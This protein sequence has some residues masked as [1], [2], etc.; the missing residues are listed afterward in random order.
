MRPY[1]RPRRAAAIRRE[2]GRDFLQIRALYEEA[3]PRALL[4]ADRALDCMDQCGKTSR[5]ASSSFSVSLSRACGN[6]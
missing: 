2:R 3:A 6:L 4:L 1:M 5:P